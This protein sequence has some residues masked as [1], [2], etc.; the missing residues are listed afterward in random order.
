MNKNYDVIRKIYAQA[1][2]DTRIKMNNVMKW[3]H[4][5]QLSV[6]NQKFKDLLTTF[7]L[8]YIIKYGH[9]CIASPVEVSKRLILAE[10][11][12]GQL[13]G[14]L[15]QFETGRIDL[16][17]KNELDDYFAKNG[18]FLEMMAF[19]AIQR[20]YEWKIEILI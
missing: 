10:I 16:N 15:Y 20:R 2:I 12:K 14:V 5:I 9:L 18:M 11:S 1:N 4:K 6:Y 7:R 13:S 8:N 19:R 3:P 17:H